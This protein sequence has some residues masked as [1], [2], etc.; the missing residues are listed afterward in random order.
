MHLH[1]RS[2]GK[3][4]GRNVGRSI[5]GMLLVM[6][7]FL[8]T[9]IPSYA[10][11][12]AAGGGTGVPDG[13]SNGVDGSSGGA[14]GTNVPDGKAVLNGNVYETVAEAVKAATSADPQNPDVIYLGKGDYTLYGISSEGSTTGK[15]LKFVGQGTDQTSW[16]IGPKEP[17]KDKEKTEYN[18]DYSFDGSEKVV[19]ERM[20]L[21]AAVKD[22]SK[23]SSISDEEDGKGWN[24]LGFIRIDNTEVLDC[25]V[26]GKT[27]YWGDESALFKNTTFNCPKGDYAVWTY[28]SPTMTFDHCTF[29]SSGKMIN[30]YTDYSADK[31]DITVNYISC[32]VNNTQSNKAVLK[33]NDQNRSGHMYKLNISGD[34]VVNGV[35]ANK[36]TCARLFGFDEEAENAGNTEVRI[37]DTLVW[38]NGKRVGDH[39]Q[40]ID[41][42]GSYQDGKAEGSSLQYTDGYKDNAYKVEYKINGAWVDESRAENDGWVNDERTVRKTCEYCGYQT[43]KTE[44]ESEPD[45]EKKEWDHS[46][47]KTATELTK[48][49]D[50][51]YTSD[52]TLSIPSAEEELASDIVFAIDDSQCGEESGEAAQKMVADL[53][54]QM[55][56]TGARIKVGVVIFGGTAI[57]SFPLQEIADEEDIAEL[58]EAMSEAASEE[59]NLHGSNIQSGLIEADSMLSADKEVEDGRKY[60]VL[61]SDGHTYQFSKEGD[62]T[63]QYFGEDRKCLTTYG[64]YNDN[65]LYSYAYGVSYTI[66]S[67]HDQYYTGDY[68]ADGTFHEWGGRYLTDD[69]Y[70]NDKG[71]PQNEYELPYGTWAQ[72]YA[73]IKKVVKEDNGA[74][75]TALEYQNGNYANQCI[76][77]GKST[78]ER[79]KEAEDLGIQFIPCGV[80]DG[81]DIALQHA[82]GVDRSVYEAY[83]KYASMAEK[84]HC[85]PV[86]VT[87]DTATDKQDYGYQ[88]MAALDA[89]SSAGTVKFTSEPSEISNIFGQIQ[90]DI[91][92][93]VGAGSTVEDV[94]GYQKGE[95]NFDL[96]N[97]A[98]ALKLKAG[99]KELTAEKVSTSDGQDEY[100]FGDPLTDGEYP[101]VL[102]YTKAADDGEKFVLKFNVPVSNFDRVELTYSVKLA[103]AT[104]QSGTHGQYDKDGS[105]GYDGW[106]TN[107]YAVLNPVDSNGESLAAEYFAKPTVSYTA[108]GSSDPKKTE[109]GT[110]TDNTEKAEPIVNT[111]NLAVGKVWLDNEDQ[112]GIRPDSVTVQLYRNGEA[113]GDPVILNEA[114]SWWYRWDNLDAESSWTVDELNVAEGYTKSFSKN[115]VNAWVIVNTHTPAAVVSTDTTV[116]PEQN[117]NLTGRG[118]GTGDESRMTLWLALMLASGI[119][120]AG[121][122]YRRRRSR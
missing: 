71:N 111:T 4:A 2:A 3:N 109:G 63:T 69:K 120:A 47:S 107:S 30:V 92:Y 32:T 41:G 77:K 97:D 52:I 59:L 42:E 104:T 89:L 11:E 110:V 96:V 1:L 74:Y 50:G 122:V 68:D 102:T 101:Y 98:A 39:E 72:Y 87:D 22:Q 73:H 54:D 23:D 64:I 61:I 65:D 113:Y 86:Y 33:I 17:V 115:A 99:D 53:L 83:N 35:E 29:N 7:L 88:L 21:N 58:K 31:T 84:Y 118:A 37:N 55:K 117:Q 27:F 82:S 81:A 60:M 16:Q 38:Q 15:S 36:I 26:T 43:E 78:E 24:Y 34:N 67:L 18:G 80:K 85:Y 70:L 56:D 28:C 79:A 95:Y 94:M 49:K 114:N 45:P 6:V 106:Y 46:K 8:G 121:I 12:P 62:Y 5:L 108:E 119:G 13:T 93:A 66:H 57:Q 9:V 44:Y 112:D 40:D 100:A 105:K 103:D 90:N 116:T 91:Y 48:Q 19:F 75:D 25:V 20:T 10:E 76:G 14:N 51:S